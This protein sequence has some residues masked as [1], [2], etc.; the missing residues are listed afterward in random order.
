M[1]NK[2]IREILEKKGIIANSR[3]CQE[4]WLEEICTENQNKGCNINVVKRRWMKAW[5]KDKKSF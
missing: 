4:N 5:W 3:F 1:R 2:N